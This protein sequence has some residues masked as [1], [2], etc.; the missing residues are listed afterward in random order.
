MKQSASFIA[1]KGTVRTLLV[2]SAATGFAMISVE[3]YWQPAYAAFSAPPWTLG[4]VTFGSF[5]GVMLGS[6]LITRVLKKH[7]NHI[8]A[9]FLLLRVLLGA[10]LIGLYYARQEASFIA[11]YVLSYF[12]LGGG[13]VAEGTL[14]HQAAKDE[15]RSSIL[16]LFS[17]VVQIGGVLASVAG[18]AVS[19]GLR[20]QLMWPVAGALLILCAGLRIARVLQKQAERLARRLFSIGFPYF[21]LSRSRISVSSTTSCGGAAGAAGLGASFFLSL[22]A[23]LTTK[24]TDSAIRKKSTTVWMNVP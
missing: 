5:I 15:Q 20:Y 1:R 14:I 23:S 13:G 18:F 2:L 3:T 22:D 24:N 6:K 12:L 11:A 9:A 17:F 10:G 16:S 4:L 8:P 21:A 19:A 7:A